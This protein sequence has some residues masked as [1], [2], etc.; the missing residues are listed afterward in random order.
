MYNVI[1]YGE[2]DGP[3]AAFRESLLRSGNKLAT[4]DAQVENLRKHGL[5]LVN[6]NAMDNIQD[7][8][9][10]LRP[11]SYRVFCFFD[12]PRN[13]FVLMNGFRKK[14]GKTPESEKAIARNLAE[15]RT[16]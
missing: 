12:R 11:G 1:P 7:D 14:G 8:V 5:D 16:D 3:Y 15:Y 10:E 13:T 6:T 9:Y 4:L 2:E